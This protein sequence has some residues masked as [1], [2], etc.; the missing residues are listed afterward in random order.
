MLIDVLRNTVHAIYVHIAASG[1]MH[2]YRQRAASDRPRVNRQDRS[3]PRLRRVIL[4]GV[5]NHLR[6]AKYRQCTAGLFVRDDGIPYLGGLAAMHGSG[7]AD[8]RPVVRGAKVIGLQLD[9]GKTAGF[10][11]ETGHAPI[12]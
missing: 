5:E 6:A 9:G 3:S 1:S 2:R 10:R 8:Y 12:A 7:D 11:R 4:P